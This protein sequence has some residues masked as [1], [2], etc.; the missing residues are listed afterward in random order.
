MVVLAS[1]LVLQVVYRPQE[2][3]VLASK[4]VL[5]VV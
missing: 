5:Q 3:V 1:K 2:M 4:L